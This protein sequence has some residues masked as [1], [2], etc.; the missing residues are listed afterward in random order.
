MISIIDYGSGNIGAIERLCQLSD[1]GFERVSDPDTISA[2]TSLILP[3]VGAI[4]TV[5]ESL[6]T[7]G[8]AE[9]IHSAV[10]S[11]RTTLLGICVGMHALAR[12]SGEGEAECLSLI[13]GDVE[14][15]DPAK[16][17]VQAK[18]PH[19]GWNSLAAPAPHHLLDG[20]DLI[21]GFYFLHSFRYAN[22]APD[23][24]VATADHGGGF[25]AI[26]GKDNVL[27]VQFH[28]EKSHG[29][30]VRLIKNFSE[31]RPC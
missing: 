11:G 27:G 9:A 13:D 19:M 14:R 12:R 8:V 20:I 15:F 18:L 17:E 2:A 31:L 7:S 26:V 28:P 30:G 23:E 4:D 6:H 29:N 25:P 16:I 1:I 10:D 21:C 22:T 3:G 5:M 24:V